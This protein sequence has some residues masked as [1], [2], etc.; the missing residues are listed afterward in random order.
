MI[1][2][3]VPGATDDPMTRR[4][5]SLRLSPVSAG[6]TVF[7][8]MRRLVFQSGD[9]EKVRNRVAQHGLQVAFLETRI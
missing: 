8:T 3:Y 5:C 7:S 9:E 6:V 1:D 4:R 2:W